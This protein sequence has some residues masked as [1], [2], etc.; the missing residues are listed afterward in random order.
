MKSKI[1]PRG[2]WQATGMQAE[3]IPKSDPAKLRIRAA[4]LKLRA[5]R[6]IKEADELFARADEIEGQQPD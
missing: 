6:L 2:P 1:R 4:E 5:E 3:R